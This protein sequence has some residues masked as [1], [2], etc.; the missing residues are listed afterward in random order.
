MAY[1]QNLSIRTASKW[2][3]ALIDQPFDVWSRWLHRNI[4]HS[5]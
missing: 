2:L 3:C 1:T 5:V 4:S